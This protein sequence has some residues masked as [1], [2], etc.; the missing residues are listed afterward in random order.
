[1]Q[2]QI[3]FTYKNITATKTSQRRASPLG[4]ILGPRAYLVA[5]DE[6][7]DA[8]EIIP[9]PALKTCTLLMGQSSHRL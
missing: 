1:M 6:E 2:K 4:I 7:A 3:T 8:L 9:S 5:H